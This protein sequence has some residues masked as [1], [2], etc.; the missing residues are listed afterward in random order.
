MIAMTD[1]AINT[2]PEA[3]RRIL[4]AVHETATDLH[5]AGFIDAKRMRRYDMLCVDRVSLTASATY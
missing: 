5:S 4:E 1:D 2:K 3:A